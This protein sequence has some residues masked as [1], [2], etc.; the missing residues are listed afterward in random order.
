MGMWWPYIEL[1]PIINQSLWIFLTFVIPIAMVSSILFLRKN[2][3][4]F[5]TISFSLIILFIMFFYKGTQPPAE[6]FI[7][8]FILSFSI[9]YGIPIVAWM[10]RLLGIEWN[11]FALFC[12]DG[13]KFWFLLAIKI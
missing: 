5:Y 8:G 2:K 3:L 10:F 4:K 1:T 9:V 11:V 12:Y 6:G 13:Y 7:H